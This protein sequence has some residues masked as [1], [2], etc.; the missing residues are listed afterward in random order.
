MFPKSILL[1]LAATLA[2]ATGGAALA[3]PEEEPAATLGVTHE[4]VDAPELPP[5]LHCPAAIV[6]PKVG[7]DGTEIP[8]RVV[9]IPCEGCEIIP[10]QCL[11]KEDC[12]NDDPCDAVITLNCLIGGLP[13]FRCGCFVG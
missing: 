3:L 11:L 12:P 7:L 6:T 13:G 4:S 9:L 5:E 8:A 2:F 1:A 10:F